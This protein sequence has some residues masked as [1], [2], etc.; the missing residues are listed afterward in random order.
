LETVFYNFA[1]MFLQAGILLQYVSIFILQ[2]SR[3][4]LFWVALTFIFLSTVLYLTACILLI[5]WCLTGSE[6][7]N[8]LSPQIR[9]KRNISVYITAAAFNVVTDV[10]II[11]LPQ[12][13]IWKLELP[14]AKKVTISVVFMGGLL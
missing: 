9:C 6:I 7:W 12:Q 5:A 4:A 13:A 10:V 2:R 8:P 1:I 11:L 14:R 3:T